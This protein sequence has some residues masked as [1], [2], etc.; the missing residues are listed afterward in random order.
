MIGRVEIS[1]DMAALL[2]LVDDR[3]IGRVRELADEYI[4]RRVGHVDQLFTE[5]W[6]PTD[7]LIRR[8]RE[9]GR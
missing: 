6:Q 3:V 9:G 4:N 2:D 7:S 8:I 5:G 1:D